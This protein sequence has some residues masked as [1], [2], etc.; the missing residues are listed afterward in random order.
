[1]S[2]SLLLLLA[3]PDFVNSKANKALVTAVQN[4]PGVNFHHLDL[5]RQNGHFDVLSETVSL[6]KAEIIIWQFPLY[7]YS[8]PSALR[9]WQDQVLSPIVYGPENFLKG[10]QV[11]V[12]FTAGARQTAFRAGDILGFTPDE[13]LRPLQMTTNAALMQWLPPFTVF[14]AGE[15]SA[16]AL[17]KTCVEYREL[18]LGL[19]EGHNNFN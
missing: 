6:R 9:D 2:H 19:V 1:M 14:G 5:H 11:L 17:E 18:V 13:M 16:E 7:W 10:K 15:M 8:C 3:H 4:L 12:V